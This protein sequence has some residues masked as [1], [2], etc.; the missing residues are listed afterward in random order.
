[1]VPVAAP[2]SAKRAS[3]EGGSVA[4]WCRTI[5]ASTAAGAYHAPRVAALCRR[6]PRARHGVALVGN[7]EKVDELATSIPNT[8]AAESRAC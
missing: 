5:Q 4:V 2:S 1:M 6:F 3:R 8:G 7:P